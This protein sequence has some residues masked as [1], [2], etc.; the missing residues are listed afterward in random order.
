M[1]N[2]LSLE[3]EGSSN[4]SIRSLIETLHYIFILNKFNGI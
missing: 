4:T 1:V 2:R 3:G